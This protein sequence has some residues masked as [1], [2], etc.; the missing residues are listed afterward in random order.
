MIRPLC[1]QA[2]STVTG[3]G[4]APGLSRYARR[5]FSNRSGKS[6]RISAATS[7][8][9]PC[10]LRM[11]AM[12]RNWSRLPGSPSD[13]QQRRN[14]APGAM[15]SGDRRHGPCAA[16]LRTPRGRAGWLE[17][18]SRPPVRPFLFQDFECKAFLQLHSGGPENGANRA[19]GAT[20]L[21]DHLAEVGR[22]NPK[23]EYRD[24]FTFDWPDLYLVRIIHQRLGDGFD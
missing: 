14:L 7:P 1:G 3:S 18:S 20:L 21:A 13:T 17:G 8:W 9:R 15:T 2:F 19:S 5:R 12:A 10:G 22:V 4:S 24:L 6:V 16:G 23:L 11:R